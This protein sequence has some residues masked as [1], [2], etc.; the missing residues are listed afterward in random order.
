VRSPFLVRVRVPAEQV[1]KHFHVDQAGR[2]HSNFRNVDAMFD[3]LRD[4]GIRF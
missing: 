3:L 4:A 1:G 2:V